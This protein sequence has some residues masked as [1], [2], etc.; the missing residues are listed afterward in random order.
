MVNSILVEACKINGVRCWKN[1]TGTFRDFS[2][3]DR[4]IKIGTKGRP[5]IEGFIKGLDRYAIHFG[6]EVKTGSGVQSREQKAYQALCQKM[7][8]PYY[9]ARTLPGALEFLKQ[10]AIGSWPCEE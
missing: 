1:H 4:I 7:S 2:N 9:V 8:V 5:D 6:I 10:V 3:F